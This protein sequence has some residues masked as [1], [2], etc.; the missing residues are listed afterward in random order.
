MSKDVYELLDRISNLLRTEVRQLG[1]EHGLHPV[2]LDILS[3]LS[4]CNQ[5]SD[6]PAALKEF[7]GITKGTL[8]QSITLLENK[9]MLTKT[10]DAVDKRVSH[11]G[12]TLVGKRLIEKLTPPARYLE[13]LSE[14]EAASPDS[15]GYLK[16]MLAQ[17]QA[18]NET[19]SFGICRTCRH[20]EDR[21]GSTFYCR[22]T[23]LELDKKFGELICWERQYQS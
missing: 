23:E 6:T 8:S 4:R 9:G 18:K 19:Q 16:K 20:H 3:Y 13:P 7:L 5:F 22:L 15:V 14:L 11:L 1:A 21:P 10:K 2:H 12:L 17:M